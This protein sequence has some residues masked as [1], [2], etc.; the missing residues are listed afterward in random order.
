MEQS[1]EVKSMEQE[2]TSLTE[3]RAR[4]LQRLKD[5]EMSKELSRRLAE[6]RLLDVRYARERKA[7]LRKARRSL[8]ES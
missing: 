2:D 1:D 6:Q 3:K 8:R 7:Q 4:E 5:K